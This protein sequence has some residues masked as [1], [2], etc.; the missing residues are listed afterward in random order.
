MSI[1]V[2]KEYDEYIA[3]VGGREGSLLLLLYTHMLYATVY[4]MEW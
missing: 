2:D 1:I 3:A 4:C